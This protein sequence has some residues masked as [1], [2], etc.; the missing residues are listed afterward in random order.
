MSDSTRAWI[1]GS[2]DHQCDH[3]EEAPHLRLVTAS[4]VRIVERFVMSQHSKEIHH[5]C[6]TVTDYKY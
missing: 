4:I 5:D 6:L 2:L 1:S 3:D